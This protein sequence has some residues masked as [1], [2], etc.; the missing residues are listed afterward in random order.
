MNYSIVTRLLSLVMVAMA[1]AFAVSAGVGYS[2]TSGSPMEAQAVLGLLVSAGVALGLAVP[3]YFGVRPVDNRIFQKEALAL[4]GLSWLSASA[5]GALPYLLVGEG[6]GLADAFFESA[7]GLTTTGA[8]IF[9]DLEEMP[10]SL[11]FWRCLSQ[12]IG[13]LGVVVFFVAILSFLGAGGKILFSRESSGQTA[14]IFDGR[15]QTGA[16]RIMLLYLILSVGSAGVYKLLGMNAYEAFCHMFTTVSTGG[17]ST[18]SASLAGFESPVIEW[19]AIGFMLICGVSF[20]LMVR[21]ARGDLRALRRSSETVAY[22]GIVSAASIVIVILLHIRMDGSVDAGTGKLIRDSVFQVVSILTTTGFATAD[23][24][25]WPYLAHI[26]LIGLMFVG[27]CSGSTAGGMK[28]TRFVAGTKILL[29]HV[30]KSFRSHVIRPVR[31]NGRVLS[32]P[33]REDVITFLLIG[34]VATAGGLV[35]VGLFEPEKDLVTVFT[36]VVA[37]LFNIGPG[38]GGVGP[39]E[40][41][42]GFADASK[43]V[44]AVLMIMGRL[45]FFAILALFLPS[46]WRSFR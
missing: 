2:Y 23:F 39:T 17:F 36:A 24:N 29:N 14:D 37:S 25:E 19:A 33:E 9:S 34:V 43:F 40:N 3:L 7:S 32:D 5:V 1:G 26:L 30:E 16:N 6:V 35:L 42:A 27:G 12:W 38:L 4:I 22:F 31:V 28:V 18:R 8:S 44:L 21:V 10:H 20:I 11:M 15:M 41:F 46:L 45:E 13:G